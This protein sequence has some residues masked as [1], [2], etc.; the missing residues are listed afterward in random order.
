MYR[1]S[2]YKQIFVVLLLLNVV[3]VTTFYRAV[4]QD[5]GTIIAQSGFDPQ[6]DSFNFA[7]YS[8]DD[9][10][11]TNMTATEVHRMFGDSVCESGTE[12]Q[13]NCTLIPTAKQWMET[14]NSEMDGGH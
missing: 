9:K 12:S 14:T 4:A 3:I 13:A 10:P 5:S 11:Y 6:I 1:R 2:I 7:N 8:T